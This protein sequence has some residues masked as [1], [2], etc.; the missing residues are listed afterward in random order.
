[1]CESKEWKKKWKMLFYK[2]IEIIRIGKVGEELG[3]RWTKW[4]ENIMSFVM[5]VLS[6]FF[7]EIING[8]MSAFNFKV[9]LKNKSF[10]F[11]VFS[12]QKYEMDTVWEFSKDMPFF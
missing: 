2:K 12:V 10:F 6:F 7:K 3:E 1:M 11:W 5:W 9:N 4:I 8:K